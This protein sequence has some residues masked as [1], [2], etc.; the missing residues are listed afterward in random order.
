MRRIPEARRARPREIRLIH[1]AGGRV[2]SRSGGLCGR[3]DGR[4]RRRRGSPCPRPGARSAARHRDPAHGGR[5]R[6][7]LPVGVSRQPDRPG[8]RD[9]GHVLHT[10]GD[11]LLR[12]GLHAAGRRRGL[13]LAR[14]RALAGIALTLPPQPRRLVGAIGADGGALGLAV[15]S[16]L[17]FHQR[18]RLL[19][20]RLVHDRPG[21]TG[22]A[23]GQC[24]RHRGHCDDRGARRLRRRGAGPAR[25]SR[26][27]LD[28]PTRPRPAPPGAR[29]DLLRP[30]YAGAVDRCHGLRLCLR[31]MAGPD[32]RGQG[33]GLPPTGRGPDGG[34][35]RPPHGEPV[36]RPRAVDGAGQSD[37]DGA[38]VPQHVEVSGVAALSS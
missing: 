13:A 2:E 8:A 10:L 1:T 6:P 20:A 3:C 22:D 38:L 28:H 33:T 15:Q 29:R 30:L 36:R 35:P 24:G 18:A 5:S 9:P 11:A 26:L 34:L 25:R 17:W 31:R 21:G 12:A 19:G 7:V 27:A 4:G 32:R 23:P 14:T 37:A 16:G